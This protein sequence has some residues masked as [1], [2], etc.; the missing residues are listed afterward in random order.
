MD[1]RDE[2]KGIKKMNVPAGVTNSLTAAIQSEFSFLVFFVCSHVQHNRALDGLVERPTPA[3]TPS[4]SCKHAGDTFY[5]FTQGPVRTASRSC[6]LNVC[7]LKVKSQRV[8]H[9]PP[10]TPS[11][12]V[13]EG[14]GGSRASVW[15]W[16][17]LLSIWYSG[18]K[19][20]RALWAISW[21]IWTNFLLRL[22]AFFFLFF[23][24]PPAC[25]FVHISG[26]SLG[27]NWWPTKPKY[28]FGSMP[29]KAGAASLNHIQPPSPYRSVCPQMRL[30]F[31][32]FEAVGGN[33]LQD[34]VKRFV[35]TL[36]PVWETTTCSL[37]CLLF[38]Y[39]T[40]TESARSVSNSTWLG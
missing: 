1:A 13:P 2:P 19:L 11:N 25:I 36:W 16:V 10:K 4:H 21:T 37:I 6:S 8:P 22:L 15:S 31:C 33:I 26:N 14:G 35:W 27:E 23:F 39:K 29:L 3:L 7:K 18:W 28:H 38:I 20:F 9:F 32:L 40:F 24:F 17:F 12:K 34:Y 5:W 30:L